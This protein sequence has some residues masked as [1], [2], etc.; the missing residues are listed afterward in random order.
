MLEYQKNSK[1][2]TIQHSIRSPEI[3]SSDFIVPSKNVYKM[4]YI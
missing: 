1:T 2:V 3:G 4:P